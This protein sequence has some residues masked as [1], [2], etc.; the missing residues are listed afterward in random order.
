M[1][2]GGIVLISVLSVVFVALLFLVGGATYISADLIIEYI[3]D[4]FF[5]QEGEW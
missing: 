5:L 3:K 1:K 2:G 4:Y